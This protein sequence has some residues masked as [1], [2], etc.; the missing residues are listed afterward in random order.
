MQGAHAH[1]S[2][3]HARTK[4]AVARV[5]A[6]HA[7]HDGTAVKAGADGDDASRRVLLIHAHGGRRRH[8]VQRERSH[9]RRVVVLLP[10]RQRA[11]NHVRVADRLHLRVAV[12]GC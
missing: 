7:G 10:L 8:G 12:A 3:K 4:E 5:G 2:A 9:A 1:V 11:A 6:A